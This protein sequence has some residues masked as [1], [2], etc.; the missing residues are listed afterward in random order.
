M[1]DDHSTPDIADVKTESPP[2]AATSSAW[3][4]TIEGAVADDRSL[5]R[6]EIR[7]LVESAENA[8]R[9]VLENWNGDGHRWRGIRVEELLARADPDPDAAY[10][11]VHAMDGDY[12]CSFPLDRLGEALLAIELDGG[13][14]P[15]E[16]GGPARLLVADEGADC[17]ESMK[18][19]SRI[20]VRIEN[21]AAEATSEPLARAHDD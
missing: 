9:T 1:A 10:A 17:W 6:A 5:S 21:P 18:W 7:E 14:V 13:P 3:R 20:D 15:A 12:S 8:D 19:I 16:R 4:L 11:L 2:E